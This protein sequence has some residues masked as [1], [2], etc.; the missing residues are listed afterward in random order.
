MAKGTITTEPFEAQI[1]YAKF[2]KHMGVIEEGYVWCIRRSYPNQW[3]KTHECRHKACK[4]D[5]KE[6]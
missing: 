5:V 2:L 6:E 4:N 1:N 3:V